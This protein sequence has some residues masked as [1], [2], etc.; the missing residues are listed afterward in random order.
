MNHPTVLALDPSTTSTGWAVV[1]EGKVLGSGHVKLDFQRDKYTMNH[2]ERFKFLR[3]QLDD[4]VDG[5]GADHIVIE[6]TFI[7]R[8]PKGAMVLVR[9]VGQLHLWAS[10]HHAFHQPN[11]IPS[12]TKSVWAKEELGKGNA[13]DEDSVRL[14]LAK[15]GVSVGKHDEADAIHIAI[16]HEKSL[17]K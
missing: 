13:T 10:D 7:G 4:V 9:F 3:N 11:D 16:F 2:L 1:R 17:K 15:H 12:Y 14:A 5:Y 8:N 6:D